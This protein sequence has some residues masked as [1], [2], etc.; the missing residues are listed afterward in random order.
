MVGNALGSKLVEL[1]H[2]VRMG[3][4][5]SGNE[6]AV[7]WV[8]RTGEGASQGAFA[9]AAD[10]GE[11]VINATSGTAS[12]AALEAAGEEALA[13]KVLIDVANPLDHST[14]P[15]SLEY[16]NDASLGERI[17]ARFPEARV[18][19]AL[20]TVNASVMTDPGSLGEPTTIF[21]CGQDDEAK[22]AAKD[23]IESFGWEREQIVDLGGIDA[24]RG[25]EMYLALWLRTM[26]AVGN[27]MFN[28]R[29]VRGE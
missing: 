29:L 7:D 18:V 11:V 8:G 13:G 20:N 6:R 5:E 10:F 19:K 2:E 23:L 16:C 27:P 25:T 28:V 26:F 9:A 21:V 17:Q 14:S 15:P 24:A 4:R 1:G 22:A 3:A 12:I